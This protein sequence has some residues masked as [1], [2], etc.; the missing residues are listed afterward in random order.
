MAVKKHIMLA[1]VSFVNPVTYKEPAKYDDIEGA[2]YAAVQTNEAAIVAAK[3]RYGEALQDVVLLLTPEVRENIKFFKDKKQTH[4]QY[5]EERLHKAFPQQKLRFH[6]YHLQDSKDADSMKKSISEISRIADVVKST[7]APNLPLTATMVHADMTGGMRHFSMMM[8]SVLQML[9][10]EG[11]SLGDVY[12]AD[13]FSEKKQLFKATPIQR[14]FTLITGVDE[15]MRFG[16]V[17]A[18]KEYFADGEQHS[19]ELKNLLAAMEF[20]SDTLRVCYTG[21]IPEAIA[22]LKEAFRVFGIYDK[23]SLQEQVFDNLLSTL[24]SHYGE[25]LTGEATQFDIIRWC[26]KNNFIQQALTLCTEWLA[27]YMVD[28]KIAYTDNQAVQSFCNKAGESESRSGKMNFVINCNLSQLKSVRKKKTMLKTTV[29][30]GE[31]RTVISDKAEPKQRDNVLETYSRLADFLRGYDRFIKDYLEFKQSSKRDVEWAYFKKRQPL[32]A[33]A[34]KLLYDKTCGQDN[35]NGTWTK[36]RGDVKYKTIKSQISDDDT[37][38]M[39]LELPHEKI[40]I[41]QS[42]PQKVIKLP[43]TKVALFTTKAL[44]RYDELCAMYREGILKSKLSCDKMLECLIAY[45][46][47]REL[48]NATNHANE[49]RD[50]ISIEKIKEQIIAVVDLLERS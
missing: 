21:Y 30:L 12:Y 18:I 6:H 25:L 50:Y 45:N 28:S 39:L 9:Q 10:Y 49:S 14:M 42:K 17:S 4:V 35:Y 48:R 31:L 22:R 46:D 40:T 3:R 24:Y 29:P 32:Y 1:F 37:L 5:L 33:R 38:I 11:L 34:I 26:V 23:T 2:P 19:E 36:F 20:F 15:F 27:D 43:A 7:A 41:M 44:K 13:N 47:I 8:L 16:S